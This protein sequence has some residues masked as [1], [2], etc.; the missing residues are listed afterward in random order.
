MNKELAK[1]LAESFPHSFGY[2]D[3]FG[4]PRLYYQIGKYSHVIWASGLDLETER[5]RLITEFDFEANVIHA[6]RD[7]C[8]R[9][10]LTLSRWWNGE[11]AASAAEAVLGIKDIIN[12]RVNE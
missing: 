8:R 12:E 7:L 2:D 1:Q 4:T 5:D 10:D 9:A 3:G 11:H 6:C